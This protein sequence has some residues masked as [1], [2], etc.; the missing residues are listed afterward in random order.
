M[1]IAEK[2]GVI[3]VGVRYRARKHFLDGRFENP[4]GD[5]RY[6][7]NTLKKGMALIFEEEMERLIKER[8]CPCCGQ[9]TMADFDW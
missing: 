9:F 8:V 7:E 1:Q 4:Y 6:L 5:A 2:Q 3:C